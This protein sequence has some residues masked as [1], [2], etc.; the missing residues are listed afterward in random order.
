[1]ARLSRTPR[2]AQ[3]VANG[4]AKA[5]PE[6]IELIAKVL[7]WAGEGMRGIKFSCANDAVDEPITIVQ[8]RDHL[9]VLLRRWPIDVPDYPDQFEVL[10][11]FEYPGAPP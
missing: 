1:M 2:S 3:R 5:K 6:D 11:L 8:P 4:K 10:G 7:E 9:Y